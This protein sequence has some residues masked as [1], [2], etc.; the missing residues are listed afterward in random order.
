MCGFDTE[1]D[2]NSEKFVPDQLNLIS[3]ISNTHIVV[4]IAVGRKCCCIIANSRD[5]KL[6]S[7]LAKESG[8]LKE[9]IDQATESH[10]DVMKMVKVCL[11]EKTAANKRVAPS[12]SSPLRKDKG[13]SDPKLWGGQLARITNFADLKEPNS[14]S[15]KSK[16]ANGRSGSPAGTSRLNQSK[17]AQSRSS[18]SSKFDA[19]LYENLGFN[20]QVASK[21]DQRI[22]FK[23]SQFESRRA[24]EWEKSEKGSEVG[25]PSDL[26]QSEAVEP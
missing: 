25:H 2:V 19:T 9:F 15:F 7:K 11:D 22:S 13:F 21:L 14:S 3:S 1:G 10:K 5:D 23:K 20:K 18:I 16:Q 17:S 8:C 12:S 4:D 24:S 6:G 26:R